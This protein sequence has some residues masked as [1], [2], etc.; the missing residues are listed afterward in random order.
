[1]MLHVLSNSFNSLTVLIQFL[2]RLMFLAWVFPSLRPLFPFGISVLTFKFL[3]GR[4]V[5]FVGSVEIAVDRHVF[6]SL[7]VPVLLQDWTLEIAVDRHV[8]VGVARFEL[9]TVAGFL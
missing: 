2:W 8:S 3:Y 9:S 7:V 6:D 1:V 5:R 4:F